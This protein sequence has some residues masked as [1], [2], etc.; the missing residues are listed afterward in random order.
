M[1][2]ID[3]KKVGERI[4]KIRTQ[5]FEEKI[6]LEA[7]GQLLSPPAI[8]PLV[9]KWEKGLNLPNEDRLKQIAKLGDVTTNYLLFGKELNGHGKRIENIRQEN[10]LTEVEFSCIFSPPVTAEVV[11]SWE[12]ENALPNLKQLK[13]IA[14]FGNMDYHE[15]LFDV[16]RKQ[17]T[18]D[19]PFTNLDFVEEILAKGKLTQ[20]EAN[21]SDNYFKNMNALRLIQKENPNSFQILHQLSNE[22]SNFVNKDSLTSYDDLDEKMEELKELIQRFCEIYYEEKSN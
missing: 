19:N 1:P 7:F 22:L 8:R 15:L 10:Q 12:E 5:H 18:L 13:K 3:N 4:K 21:L 9:S 16:K 6:S 2:I 17:T 20:Q 11:Q 14:Q